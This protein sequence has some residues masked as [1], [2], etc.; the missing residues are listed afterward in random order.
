MVT[1]TTKID[2]KILKCLKKKIQ[3]P[4]YARPTRPINVSICT[5]HHQATCLVG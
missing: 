2:G 3:D 4:M 5:R 1:F